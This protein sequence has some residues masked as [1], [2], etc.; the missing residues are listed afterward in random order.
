MIILKKIN[1]WQNPTIQNSAILIENHSHQRG[2]WLVDISNME[3]CDLFLDK[4][5]FTWENTS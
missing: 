1:K 5:C 3:F 2:S 4:S